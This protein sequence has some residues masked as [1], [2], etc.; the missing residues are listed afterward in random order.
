MNEDLD[1]DRPIEKNY[2]NGFCA[3][4]D[5]TPWS[6]C[7][8]VCRPTR[9]ASTKVRKRFPL[10][11]MPPECDVKEEHYYCDPNIYC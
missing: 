1:R 10:E 9:V 2:H 5:W 7:E 11:G 6:D 8:V 4:K 3:Y